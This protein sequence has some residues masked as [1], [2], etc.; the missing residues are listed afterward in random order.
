MRRT[1]FRNLI[2]LFLLN[3]VIKPLWVLGID[4][5]VQNTTGA[6]AYGL[7]FSLSALTMM[8]NILL[9]MG[10]TYYNNRMV[11]QQPSRIKNLLPHIVVLKV[12]FTS[13]YILLT[14]IV[15]YVSQIDSEAYP[16]LMM[17]CMNQIL[18]SAIIYLRSNISGLHH[19]KTDSLLS[20][21]DKVLMLLLFGSIFLMPELKQQFNIEWFIYGQTFCYA[22]TLL[23]ALVATVKFSGSIEWRISKTE[24]HNIWRNSYPYVLVIFFMTI[25]TRSDA[26]IIE[27]FSGAESAGHYAAAYRL[28]DAANQ[29]GYLFAAL[30]L[31]IFSRMLSGNKKV[32]ELMQSAFIAISL[33]SSI[34]VV[35]CFYHGNKIMEAL[36]HNTIAESGITLTL[37]MMSLWGSF[38]VYI[39][40][41]LL[42][43]AAKLKALNAITA[44]AAVSS[45]CL[46]L[47][48]IQAYGI[49][50]AAVT[51]VACNL[52]VAIAEYIYIRKQ[53]LEY[54]ETAVLPKLIVLIILMFG[55]GR[56]LSLYTH[57][58]WILQ[59]IILIIMCGLFAFVLRLVPVGLLKQMLQLARQD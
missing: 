30:L 38:S 44:I 29:F 2:F 35:I 43:A 59:C 57:A 18:L 46:N 19:F 55:A 39:F 1:F 21:T 24:L 32:G 54:I 53:L 27:R 49:I 12:V 28:L 15:A 34:V 14:F 25:Y 13:V 17:L 6:S 42:A 37:L 50:G 48:A 26:I 33:L 45:V 9:D 22:I 11:A 8:F 20:I 4:R 23:I 47:L 7:Y 3:I 36:Y 10:M 16:M 58:G 51:S 40:G 5:G 31:P 41:T 52:F 56:I